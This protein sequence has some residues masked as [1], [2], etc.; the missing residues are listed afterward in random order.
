MHM[1]SGYLFNALSYTEL[2]FILAI[3]KHA[4]NSVLH[5]LSKHVSKKV[6]CKSS[7][8]LIGALCTLANHS[9][10]LNQGE[11]FIPGLIVESDTN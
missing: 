5:S 9:T 10:K 4:S 2:N 3:A 8:Q 11:P 6:P 7:R 1:H